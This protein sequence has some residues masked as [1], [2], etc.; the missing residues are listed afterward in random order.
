LQAPMWDVYAIW[1]RS[2]AQQQ[3][4]ITK[5]A[6]TAPRA[7]IIMNKGMDDH[8]ALRFSI[9]HQLVHAY[10]L[11]TYD[12]LRAYTTLPGYSIFRIR[13]YD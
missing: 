3:S 7:V 2:D 10:I 8:S 4:E 9:S 11:E 13:D 6:I 12:Q 5:I 1:P